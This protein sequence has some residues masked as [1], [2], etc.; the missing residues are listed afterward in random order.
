M[1]SEVC[2]HTL[3]GDGD[4]EIDF[5]K[6]KMNLN[7]ETW[8]HDDERHSDQRESM[9]IFIE[10]WNLWCRGE[11][12]SIIIEAIFSSTVSQINVSSCEDIRSYY[13]FHRKL[14]SSVKFQ[15]SSSRALVRWKRIVSW[16]NNDGVSL[17]LEFLFSRW[18]FLVNPYGRNC[19]WHKE[20]IDN[21]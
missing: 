8:G 20:N 2:V 5:E 13:S 10:Y 17:L 21:E 16:T 12:I 6:F 1:F 7:D 15:L 9:N 14:H 11:V 19:Y 4:K 18:I 3:M